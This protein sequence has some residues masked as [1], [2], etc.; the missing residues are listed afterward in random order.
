MRL[1]GEGVEGLELELGL[2]SE[3]ESGLGFRLEGI[4]EGEGEIDLE[5]KEVIWRC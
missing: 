1:Q 4:E 3:M 5:K 2:R